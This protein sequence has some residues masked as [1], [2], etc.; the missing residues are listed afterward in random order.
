MPAAPQQSRYYTFIQPVIKN[1][2]V[3][4][5]APYVFS[6]VTVTV[7]LVFAIRPTVST[8]L[9]LKTKIAEEQQTLDA[10]ENKARMIQEA[11]ANYDKLDPAVK[12]KIVAAVP[13]TV[14]VTDLL[15]D[16]ESALPAQASISAIQVQPL[17]L[18]DEASPSANKAHPDL[19]EVDFTYNITGNY[20]QVLVT[21]D[22]LRRVPRLIN[23]RNLVVSKPSEEMIMTVTAKAY[24]L[25]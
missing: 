25:K 2:Y 9:V 10:L 15:R 18:L 16:L 11:K 8:I 14:E 12:A 6:L 4:S 23:I 20:N 5:Y 7:L 24:Y 13:Q 3:R 1:P 19:A 22:N 21:L 17:T